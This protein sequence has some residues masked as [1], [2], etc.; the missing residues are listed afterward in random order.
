MSGKITVLCCL[1]ES[2][3]P[4]FQEREE[5]TDIV[6]G[7]ID[8]QDL[9]DLCDVYVESAVWKKTGKDLTEEQLAQL[10]GYYEC[11]IHALAY[12]QATGGQ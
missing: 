8:R 9:P 2:E 11:E 5:V 6:L 3:E 1:V 12:R 10:L 4:Q 7:G